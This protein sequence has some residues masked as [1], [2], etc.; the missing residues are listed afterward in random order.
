MTDPLHIDRNIGKV[1]QERI[2]PRTPGV[3]FA[4]FGHNIDIDVVGKD[5]FVVQIFVHQQEFAVYPLESTH[6]DIS[7]S[8]IAVR[9]DAR[10]FGEVVQVADAEEFAAAVA[11]PVFENFF[12]AG[13]VGH[14]VG[15]EPFQTAGGQGFAI[16]FGHGA[17]VHGILQR[18]GKRADAGDFKGIEV[19]FKTEVLVAPVELIDHTVLTAD[20]GNFLDEVFDQF[21]VE[22]HPFFQFGSGSVVDRH[23]VQRGEE[24]SRPELD[25]GIFFKGFLCGGIAVAGA[26]TPEFPP[27]HPFAGEVVEAAVHVMERNLIFVHFAEFFPVSQIGGGLSRA[28]QRDIQAFDMFGKVVNGVTV[29]GNRIL[30]CDQIF[31]GIKSPAGFGFDVL[32]GRF[33]PQL[34]VTVGV[35]FEVSMRIFDGEFK[36]F[37]GFCNSIGEAVS[38]FFQIRIF[39]GPV[40]FDFVRND[41]A[42]GGDFHPFALQKFELIGI[43]DT[44]VSVIEVDD[45]IPDI[46]IF[47]FFIEEFQKIR[48]RHRRHE[49]GDR[50]N[51]VFAHQQF[52]VK[53][54]VCHF[55][56]TAAVLEELFILLFHQ[57]EVIVV[58]CDK[59]VVQI[60]F[61]HIQMKFRI[62]FLFDHLIKNFPAAAEVT[63]SKTADDLAVSSFPDGSILFDL[64]CCRGFHVV[65]SKE[66]DFFAGQ[67]ETAFGNG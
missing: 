43:G 13:G 16:L 62:F 39:N 54:S 31:F 2:T 15:E 6:I 20:I 36:R 25:A 35:K 12:G 27:F 19:G 17:D 4:P 53:L 44:V 37:V 26:V 23:A 67:E 10:K 3:L 58:L 59:T 48:S 63:H 47:G 45:E 9:V 51:A 50:R 22:F 52:F 21:L 1:T 49:C 42:A 38:D 14:H 29:S 61:E 30:D 7:Q 46:E 65:H 11:I 32:F 8:S 64:Y 40:P 34:P 55:F 56:Q 41:A 60:V 5:L 57:T 28:G 66:G 24:H 33:V 18:T